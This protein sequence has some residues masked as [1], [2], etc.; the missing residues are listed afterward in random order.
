MAGSTLDETEPIE[1]IIPDGASDGASDGVSDET[2]IEGFDLD[3][4]SDF[5]RSVV[6][7]FTTSEVE[8][9]PE[10]AVSGVPSPSDPPADTPADTS[11]DTSAD[12]PTGTPADTPADTDTFDFMGTKLTM[13]QGRDLVNLYEWASSLTP[14]QAQRVSEALADPAPSAP[15]APA[16][17][18]PAPA[19][20][21][22]APTTD[23]DEFTDPAVIAKIRE[24]DAKIAQLDLANTATESS[25]QAQREAEANRVLSEVRA[26]YAE[27]H[28]LNEIEMEQ[29][30]ARTYQSGVTIHLAPQF[31]DPAALF[32]AA[33][34][35][36]LWTEP[37]FREREIARIQAQRDS[38]TAAIQSRN[39]QKAKLSAGLNGSSGSLPRKDPAPRDL[40]PGER[41]EA[42][43]AEFRAA[44]G[45]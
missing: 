26:S 7:G 10:S 3:G 14:E 2:T 36:T 31:K 41:H 25:L 9:T 44:Q 39:R 22:P 12:T 45:G 42:M 27:Q 21:T 35:Q 24:L 19:P 4:L 1:D 34:D 13:A 43:V 32:T 37:S 15:S 38:E 30:M 11:T 17:P 29:L 18:A 8:G 20:A 5:E 28:G 6:E 23:Y 33:F 40:T 16:S